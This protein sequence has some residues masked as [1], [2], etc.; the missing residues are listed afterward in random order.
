[1]AQWTVQNLNVIIFR[2]KEKALSKRAALLGQE[3][4]KVFGAFGISKET[5][6]SLVFLLKL[7]YA[8]AQGKSLTFFTVY[9]VVHFAAA[10][11]FV[12]CCQL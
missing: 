7:K 11:F 8:G 1:M 2:K 9:T 4:N 12:R 10:F 3:C 5:F 6:V